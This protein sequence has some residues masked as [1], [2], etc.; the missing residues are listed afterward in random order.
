VWGGHSLRQAQGRLWPS[1]LT[2][3]SLTIN[4]F[5]IATGAGALATAKWRN[6]LLA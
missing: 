6:L 1:L 5:V 3:T 4:S 2:L